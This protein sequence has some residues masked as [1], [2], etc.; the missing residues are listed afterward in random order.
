M[1]KVQFMGNHT[2][3]DWDLWYP[4]AAATGLSFARGRCDPTPQMLVHAVPPHLTVT[5]Y[6][7]GKLI[8]QGI[9]LAA[10]D[11]TPI[12]LLTVSGANITRRDIWPDDR[13]FGTP[14]LL[15]GG[16]VGI[17]L[18]WWNAPDHSEWRWQ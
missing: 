16:E 11:E 17:L 13:L 3:V 8:A 5:V 2:L 12:T 10:T 1:D 7:D 15:P 6:Q 14:V 9:D 4:K 18:K